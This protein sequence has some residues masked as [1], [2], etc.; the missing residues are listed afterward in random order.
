ME[1]IQWEPTTR[2]WN[3]ILKKGRGEAA[4]K[5]VWLCQR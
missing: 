4:K 1:G 2:D 3:E 5:D